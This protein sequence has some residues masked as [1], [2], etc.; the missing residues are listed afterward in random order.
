MLKLN[1]DKH[2]RLR[3]FENS[4]AFLRRKGFS[5]W[6]SN[7]L[8]SP[9]L[10]SITF[11]DLERLCELFKCT[12]NDLFEWTPNKGGDAKNGEHP[13]SILKK[14]DSV[15]SEIN[16]LSFAQLKEIARVLKEKK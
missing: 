12:P 11:D 5:H 14:D 16:Q 15:T 7:Q 10:N 1:I 3:N 13:L 8:G 2:C 4:P 9:N 6:K